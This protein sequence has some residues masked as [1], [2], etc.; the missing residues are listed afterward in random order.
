MAVIRKGFGKFCSRACRNI[1]RAIPVEI[2]FWAMVNKTKGCWL[3]TGRPIGPMKYGNIF[4]KNRHYEYAHRVSW[5][6]H[7]GKIPSG[8]KVLH[9]CDTPLCVRPDHLFLGNTKINALDASAKGRL[10]MGERHFNSKFTENQIRDI[11]NST[12]TESLL[13]NKY[14]VARSTIRN[15]VSRKRWKHVA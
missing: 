14:K 9:Q 12:E 6:L 4:I 3:W 5:E 15:I 2:R 11:R 13:A 8:M 10:A 7:Y 1:S